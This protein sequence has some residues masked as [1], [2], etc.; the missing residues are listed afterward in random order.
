MNWLWEHFL[1]RARIRVRITAAVVAAMTAILT[2]AS[3][4]VYWKVAEAL[5][6]QVD[7]D[8]LA[9]SDIVTRD[10]IAGQSLPADDPGLV[11][12]TYTRSGAVLAKSDGGVRTLL[13]ARRAAG[14]GSSAK[15]FDLGRLLPPPEQNPYRVRYFT[16]AAPTG[17]VVVAVGISRHKHDDALRDLMTQLLFAD[18]A[19]ILGA[20][21]VGW[22]AARAALNPVERYRV[23]AASAGGDPSRRLPVEPGRQDELTRLGTTFNTL[24]GEIE[25]G[26]QR[27][28]QFL[29]D[30]SHELRTPLSLLVAEV[31]WV[32]HR[33]RTPEE[34]DEVLTSIQGHTAHMVDL[35][36]ALLDIEEISTTGELAREPVAISDLVQEVFEPLRA[37]ATAAGRHLVDE[38]GAVEVDADP[39]W[40]SRA[41]SNLVANGLK[42]GRG[43]VAVRAQQQAGTT[44]I[45]VVDEGPGIPS[46]L[47]TRAFDRFARADTSR[48]TPGNGLGLAITASV[49]TRH[50]GTVAPI[51]GGVRLTL[52]GTAATG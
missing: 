27:E 51:P 48:S 4:V 26:Q 15:Q 42:H 10:V 37:Q 34:V 49:A 16:V 7:Q 12:Q 6:V 1:P 2:C 5:S 52:P 17:T 39:L 33:R 24:L 9:Y 23:A 20:G 28:R 11:S 21:V 30:A 35:A 46:E 31:E 47:G 32:R 38:T 18:L 22:G 19:T 8:L 40:L 36:N 13:S 45:D 50:G 43:T 44:T 14:A 25:E 29:A 3:A 41:L